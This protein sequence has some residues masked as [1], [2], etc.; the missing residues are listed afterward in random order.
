M[1]DWFAQQLYIFLMPLYIA[2]NRELKSTFP[3]HPCTGVP[4][5]FQETHHM[6]SLR[7]ELKLERGRWSTKHS[8]PDRDTSG[9]IVAQKK[10]S[11]TMGM[12]GFL[13]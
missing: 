4:D 7:F 13:L 5:G 2:E 9:S 1:V 11:A 8:F 3:R 10:A 12:A 6:Y